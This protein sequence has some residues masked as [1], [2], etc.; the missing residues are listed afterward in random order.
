MRPLFFLFPLQAAA[1]AGRG[2][3]VDM[4]YPRGGRG[5]GAAGQ[6]T[7]FS[8]LAFSLLAFSLLAFSLLARQTKVLSLVYL[9]Y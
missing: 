8:L 7:Q 3:G 5:R 9:R 6:G 4:C 1:A 2:P